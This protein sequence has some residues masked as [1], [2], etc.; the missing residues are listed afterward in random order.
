[1]T[2]FESL[3]GHVYLTSGQADV[4]QEHDVI[5]A[6]SSSRPQGLMLSAPVARA[7]AL[8]A[9]LAYP[10]GALIRALGPDTLPTA[11]AGFG[12]ILVAAVAA[13][14]LMGSSVQRIASEQKQLLDEYELSLRYRA[15]TGAYATF[16]MLALVGLLYCAIASDKGLWFPSTYE[17]LN[18]VFWGVF[19]YASVLPSAFVAWM[20]D[21]RAEPAE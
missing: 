4:T 12:L 17:Q 7:A 3:L 1:M 11:L 16:A 8:T 21:P 2:T 6:R 10:A 19:L 13:A 14:A 20:I 9:L 18:G 15:T 5:Y